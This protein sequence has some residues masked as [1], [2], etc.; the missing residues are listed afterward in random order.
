[1]EVGTLNPPS[2]SSPPSPFLFLFFFHG[3]KE[4]QENQ[5]NGGFIETKA[6]RLQCV[7]GDI[8]NESKPNARNTIYKE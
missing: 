8:M 7:R 5:Q 3:K 6:S 1:M 4:N 2:S